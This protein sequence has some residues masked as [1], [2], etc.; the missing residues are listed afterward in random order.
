VAVRRLEDGQLRIALKTVEAYQFP[1]A[2][3]LAG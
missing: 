3:L 1:I 2:E